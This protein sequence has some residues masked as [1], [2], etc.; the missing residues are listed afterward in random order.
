MA[1]ATG[2]GY[3]AYL[4]R[5]VSDNV[6]VHHDLLPSEPVQTDPQAAAA[7][8][9]EAATRSADPSDAPASSLPVKIPG[10]GINVL[11]IG[12]DTEAVEGGRSDVIILAHVSEARD[13]VALIHFPRDLYVSVP[14]HEKTKINAAY[15]YGGSK[16]L[17]TTVQNLLGIVVDHVA[18][19]GFVGFQRMTDAVG[20]VDVV[21]TQPSTSGGYAFRPGVTHMDGDMALAFVRER[22][23]LSGGDIA[24]GQRQ[25]AFLKGLMLKGLSR[26]TITNPFQLARFLDAGT[27]NVVVDSALGADGI[28]ALGLGLARI[29]RDDIS[30]ITAPFAGFASLPSAG[31]VELLDVPRMTALGDAVRTDRLAQYS[32]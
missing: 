19:T 20:G 5:V 4:G 32:G 29:R 26:E 30:F 24:R 27:K 1:V 15:A 22:K 8:A 13:R 11:I 16:L 12:S 7:G 2:V 21:V 17:V 28:R 10:T 23:Q 18:M 25:Q 3:A 31:A 9:A 14:G 6:V